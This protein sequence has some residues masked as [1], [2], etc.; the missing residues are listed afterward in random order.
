MEAQEREVTGW[1]GWSVFAAV[2]L[3]M[4]GVFNIIAG[5]IAIFDD[6]WLAG[7]GGAL[8]VWDSTAW[9]WITLIVGIIVLFA[10]F[11]ILKGQVWGRTIGVIV[12]LLNAANQLSTIRAYPVWSLIVILLDVFV[13][14]ALTVHGGELKQQF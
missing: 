4:V 11:A 7:S 13:I 9:G 3:I 10:A 5:L 14:Y 6:K 12:A 8:F 2:I 1:V